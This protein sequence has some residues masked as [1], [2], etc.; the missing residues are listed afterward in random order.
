MDFNRFLNSQNLYL[1]HRKPR[2]NGPLLL[3]VAILEASEA[4]N[5]R[6]WLQM[7]WMEMDCNLKN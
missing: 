6:L 7:V 1:W 3:P 5:K 2:N 4:V